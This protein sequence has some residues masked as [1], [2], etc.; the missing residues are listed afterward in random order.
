[1]HFKF[2]VA[3]FTL[4][5]AVGLHIGSSYLILAPDKDFMEEFPKTIPRQNFSRKTI[6]DSVNSIVLFAL[7]ANKN[8]LVSEIKKIQA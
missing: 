4:F 6:Q 1:M 8:R 7:Y 2:G 5:H 3:V